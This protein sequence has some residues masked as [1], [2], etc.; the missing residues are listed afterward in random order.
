MLMETAQTV[1]HAGTALG[2]CPKGFA[3]CYHWGHRVEGSG[4]SPQA[5]LISLHFRRAVLHRQSHFLHTEGQDC[6]SSKSMTIHFTAIV[7]LLR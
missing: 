3:R 2:R 7:A 1:T 4:I 6:A 5:D